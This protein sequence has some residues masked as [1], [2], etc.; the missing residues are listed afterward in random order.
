MNVV[1]I[2]FNPDKYTNNKDEP[3]KSC[4]KIDNKTGKCILNDVK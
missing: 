1:F 2:R 4:F 3:I